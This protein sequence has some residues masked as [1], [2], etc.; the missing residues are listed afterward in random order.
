[1][2]N[3][4]NCLQNSLNE[5]SSAFNDNCVNKRGLKECS[6]VFNYIC[7]KKVKINR[8]AA[9]LYIIQRSPLAT[10]ARISATNI[11]LK[12]EKLRTHSYSVTP[13]YGLVDKPRSQDLRQPSAPELANSINKGIWPEHQ[14]AIAIA[15]LTLGLDSAYK[16]SCL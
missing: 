14:M 4:Y 7:L 10:P 8:R 5:C 6:N 11:K 13:S 3:Y 1:M 16:H 12:T 2:L 15:V 9:Q